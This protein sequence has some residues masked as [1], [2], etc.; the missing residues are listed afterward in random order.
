MTWCRCTEI[1]TDTLID[2]IFF[3]FLLIKSVLYT[4]TIYRELVTRFDAKVK[5]NIHQ[6]F[7]ELSIYSCVHTDI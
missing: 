1:N 2:A 6:A 3:L 5:D 7:M 4:T